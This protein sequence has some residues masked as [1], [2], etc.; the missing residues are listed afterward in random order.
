MLT[1]KI[2]SDIRTDRNNCNSPI[3][4]KKIYSREFTEVNVPFAHLVTKCVVSLFTDNFFRCG[5]DE[6]KNVCDRR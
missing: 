6:Q 4:K 2:S 1:G 5:A 3:Y